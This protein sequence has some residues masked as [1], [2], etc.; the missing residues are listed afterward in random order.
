MGMGDDDRLDIL[1]VVSEG[2]KALAEDPIM[3]R[4]ACVHDGEAAGFLEHIPVE[5]IGVEMMD[6]GQDFLKR[7]PEYSRDGLNNL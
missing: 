4:E 1:D 7:D 3:S 5:R 6:A 2:A